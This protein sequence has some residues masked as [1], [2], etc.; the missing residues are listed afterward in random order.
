MPERK[1]FE[2]RPEMEKDKR[3]IKDLLKIL[4]LAIIFGVAIIVVTILEKETGF[5][6][7]MAEKLMQ[8]T[9]R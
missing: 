2:G 1:S 9:I 3:F 7:Q 8:A 4:V 6:T 5:F